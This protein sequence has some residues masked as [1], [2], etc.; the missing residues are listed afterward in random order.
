MVKKHICIFANPAYPGKTKTRLGRQIGFNNAASLS[1]AMLIDL[2]NEA[3]QVKDTSVSLWYPPNASYLDF[4]EITHTVDQFYQQQGCNLG[5]FMA[6]AFKWCLKQVRYNR[7]LIIGSDCISHNS[8]NLNSAFNQLNKSSMIIQPAND[9]GYVLVGQS[10][11][12]SKIFADI[13]WGSEVVMRQTREIIRENNLE[14]SELETSFDVDTLDDLR[15]LS[16]FLEKECSHR[17]NK[18]RNWFKKLGSQL[19]KDKFS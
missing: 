11:Y 1:K 4:K 6:D 12:C 8:T 13:D 7:V 2:V 18:T 17:F 10:V 14:C 3:K 5:E 9:G 19:I 16:S 15:V